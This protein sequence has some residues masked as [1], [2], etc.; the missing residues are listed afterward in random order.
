MA[1]P[2]AVDG[3]GSPTV[4]TRRPAILDVFLL[5]LNIPGALGDSEVGSEQRPDLAP[6][7]PASSAEPVSTPLP[8]RLHAARG[9]VDGAGNELVLGRDSAAIHVGRPARCLSLWIVP[10]QGRCSRVRRWWPL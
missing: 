9:T 8:L 4:S 7:L 1:T 3:H 5:A 6:F 2:A 10:G